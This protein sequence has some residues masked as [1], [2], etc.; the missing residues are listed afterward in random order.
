MVRSDLTVL[1][2]GRSHSCYTQVFL[3]KFLPLARLAKVQAF[4]LIFHKR[5]IELARAI[6]KVLQ[7]QDLT[8]AIHLCERKLA[9]LKIS[10][11]G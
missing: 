11:L 3:L 7:T 10:K 1:Q 5:R 2:A 6:V 9:L 8:C 4:W